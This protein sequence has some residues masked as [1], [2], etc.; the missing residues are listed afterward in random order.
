MKVKSN[1]HQATNLK[2]TVKD[3]IKLFKNH[4]NW[5]QR[6]NTTT[7]LEIL[8][9]LIKRFLKYSGKTKTRNRNF[10]ASVLKTHTQNS[11]RDTWLKVFNMSTSTSIINKSFTL[12]FATSKNKS[13]QRQCQNVL[14]VKVQD[15]N[16]AT[17]S[18]LFSIHPT[19]HTLHITNLIHLQVHQKRGSLCMISS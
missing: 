5:R 6:K 14:T 16:H 11:Y 12:V 13:I 9:K 3:Q 19:H 17:A 8:L 1:K 15:K 7:A 2:L 10:T 18:Y 4:S